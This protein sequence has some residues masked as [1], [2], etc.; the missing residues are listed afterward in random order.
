M[1]GGGSNLH[2]A[3]Q[4]NHRAFCG[5][6][7]QPT[8]TF[9]R[10]YIRRCPQSCK[11]SPIKPRVTLIMWSCVITRQTK[12]IITPVLEWLWSKLCKTVACPDGLL[13]IK[14]Q[15]CFITL[16][17]KIN[18]LTKTVYLHFHSAYS[19]QNRKGGDLSWEAP[20]YKAI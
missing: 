17:C 10:E 1:V 15:R 19:H 6:I 4:S 3:T 13:S 12:I 20:N 2:A 8:F 18:W 7:F 14:S 5:W 11:L 16:S 9:F